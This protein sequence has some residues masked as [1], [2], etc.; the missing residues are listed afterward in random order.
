MGDKNKIRHSYFLQTV[1]ELT[2]VLILQL[3]MLLTQSHAT[4]RPVTEQ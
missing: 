1:L 2:E 3:L 4:V